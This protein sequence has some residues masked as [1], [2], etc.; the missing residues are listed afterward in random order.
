M[1]PERLDVV[2][3]DTCP[4]CAREV[5]QYR[6]AAERTGASI[7]FH[8]LSAAARFGLTEEEAARRLHVFAGGAR[9]AGVPAFLA[10]WR[11]L[12]G[13]GRLARVAGSPALRPALEWLYERAA[14]PA[15][16]A[17]HRRRQG[18][19]I[20][21]PETGAAQPVVPGAEVGSPRATRTAR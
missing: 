5:A 12:P 17:L 14:A 16:Y 18:R 13:F 2:H 7:E 1:E 8:P 19:A 9:L 21:P 11:A 10:L 6:R 15:L 3:N 20:R 4:I